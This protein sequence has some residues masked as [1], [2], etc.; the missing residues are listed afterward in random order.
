MQAPCRAEGG[1]N[2]YPTEDG[3]QL[4]L[5]ANGQMDRD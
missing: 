2:P 1:M 5:F 4:P 3:F